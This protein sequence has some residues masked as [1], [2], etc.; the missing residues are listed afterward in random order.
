MNYL[1]HHALLG[2]DVYTLFSQ[3]Y[4]EGIRNIALSFNLQE[5]DKTQRIK[6]F[7][8]GFILVI[9][10]INTLAL[11]ILRK[12]H[13][14][15]QQANF[16]QNAHALDVPFTAWPFER[17][18]PKLLTDGTSPYPFPPDQ[19]AKHLI[20]DL[21]AEYHSNPLSHQMK[22]STG[23]EGSLAV[24][25]Q[26][27]SMEFN[28]LLENIPWESLEEK[29]Q[30]FSQED[31]D[32]YIK[33]S[34]VFERLNQLQEDQPS[35]FEAFSSPFIGLYTSYGFYSWMN[36]LLRK[37]ELPEGLLPYASQATNQQ[38]TEKNA[39]IIAKIAK[40]ILFLSLVTTAHLNALPD[41]YQ[42]KG[43]VIRVTQLPKTLMRDMQNKQTL[44]ER[45]FLSASGPG[46][47][48]AGGG[49]A[50]QD[51]C[52]VKFVIESKNGKQVSQ[53]SHL[54]ENEVLFRP[55]SEFK[56]LKIAGDEIAG[57]RIDLEECIT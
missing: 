34:L 25:Y 13:H 51:S 30:E 6:H 18:K 27:Y 56:I 17:N 37:G 39:V 47:G 43:K 10:L 9:P 21:F 15:A 12:F 14:Y 5:M 41:D 33:K 40:E 55:F 23:L 49:P 57:F 20:D 35:P 46:G 19:M 52:R 50:D 26:G 8:I 29:W 44:F 2:N 3:P 48:F 32:L 4:K 24:H 53:F 16:K 36:P 28:E 11:I 7:L 45:A 22:V 1:N 38:L 54:K 42:A 31:L